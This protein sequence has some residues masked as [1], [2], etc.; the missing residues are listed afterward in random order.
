MTDKSKTAFE[1]WARPACHPLMHDWALRDAC[2]DYSSTWVQSNWSAWQA[3]RKVAL[4]DA[5][6]VAATTAN[7]EDTYFADGFNQAAIDIEL[8]IKELLK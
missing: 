1:A 7:P 6:T 3:S 4:E 5:L 8:G 2:G